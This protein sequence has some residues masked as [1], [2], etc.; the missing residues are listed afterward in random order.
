MAHGFGEAAEA[1]FAGVGFEGGDLAHEALEVG[2][3]SIRNVGVGGSAGGVD[4]N[5]CV[6]GSVVGCNVSESAGGSGSGD[7]SNRPRLPQLVEQI[8]F[9][10][11]AP[12]MP[13]FVL[14][15]KSPPAR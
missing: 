1:E 11:K 12:K 5:I 10:E 4:V 8:A 7:L 9:P 3:G 13:S 15:L 14:F 6:G 2:F